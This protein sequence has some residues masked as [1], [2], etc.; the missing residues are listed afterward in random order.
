MP[1]SARY[2]EE[3]RAQRK[4]EQDVSILS[5]R[6]TAEN[7]ALWRFLAEECQ[8]EE[9][10]VAYCAAQKLKNDGA[11]KLG[12]VSHQDLMMLIHGK[13]SGS[14]AMSNRLYEAYD[15]LVAADVLYKVHLGS[16]GLYDYRIN[17]AMVKYLAALDCLDNIIKGA[18]FTVAKYAM[19]TVAV[20][21]D[22][23]GAE[24]AG[25]GALIAYEDKFMIL[26]N[27]HVLDPGEGCVLKGVLLGGDSNKEL[28]T[29]NTQ[30]L[31]ATDDLAVLEVDP[32]QIPKGLPIFRLSFGLSILE[33]VVSLGYPSIPRTNKYFLTAH[34]G[35]L[36][37]TITTRDNEEFYL[38]SSFAAPGSS[39]G[40]ILDF[41]GLVSAVVSQRLE[42]KYEGGLFGHTAAVS[43]QRIVSFL[44]QLY[45]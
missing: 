22:K 34:S 5:T 24:S 14:V 32:G 12:L 29:N 28:H 44:S 33:K 39:G 8:S 40:P 10:F 17:F 21:I 42:G 6:I 31:A 25:T 2:E 41:R 36:N 27:R 45:G 37:S 23:D 18:D 30:H 4:Q 26:T 43:H 35:E 38:I 19:P 15:A 3:F 1:F 7:D 9:K 11:R 20:V 13:S 16:R